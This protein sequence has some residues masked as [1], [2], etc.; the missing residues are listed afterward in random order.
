MDPSCQRAE[1]EEDRL[2]E[3]LDQYLQS[4]DGTPA[5]T[6]SP[7]T[8]PE[9]ARLVAVVECLHRLARQLETTT[10]EAALSPGAAAELIPTPRPQEVTSSFSPG[11]PAATAGVPAQVGKFEVVHPLGKGGQALTLLAFD[12]DLRQH[13]VLKLYHSAVTPKE[14]EAVLGEGRALARVR[15]PY[16]VRCL[17]AERTGGVPYLVVEYVR[18]STLAEL[19]ARRPLTPDE[20][21]LLAERLAEGLAEVHACG[22]LHR[23]LKP[24]NVLVGED[25][26]PRLIDFGLAA[27]LA[28]AD[29]RRVAGTF[30]YMAPEQARGESERIDARTDLYGLGAILY[31]LLTG[32]P[33]HSGRSPEEVLA[34]ARAGRVVP[35]VKRRQGLP[36]W[37]NDLCQRCLAPDPA[38]RFGSARE[39]ADAIRR[40]RQVRRRTRLLV[41]AAA[42]LLLATGLAFWAAHNRP[43]GTH[44][45]PAGQADTAPHAP[46]GRKLRRDFPLKVVLEGGRFDSRRKLHLLDDGQFIAFK[47]EAARRCYLGIWNVTASGKVIQLFPNEAD[48]D[49]ELPSGEVRAIP[50]DSGKGLR[51]RASQGRE[52]VHVVAATRPWKAPAAR[53]FGPFDVFDTQE[54]KKAFAGFLRELELVDVAHGISEEVLPFQVLPP[55]PEPEE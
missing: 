43:G 2:G 10:E 35:P 49:N 38:A 4:L 32:Q 20:A 13:V 34:A 31:E 55:S 42:A 3:Q 29:L 11:P 50:G 46:D 24:A 27:A 33:P 16:V 1:R 25:G 5:G 22:L 15:S 17:S 45:P 28:S 54:D 37:L 41:G 21:A 23:D 30:A 12:P 36:R 40:H 14:Q 44:E 9:L 7:D 47:V 6:P 19:H 18:G 39:L 26:R 8:D 51:A 53:K 52:Y 48:P